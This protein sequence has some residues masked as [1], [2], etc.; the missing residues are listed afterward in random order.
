MMNLEKFDVK[1]RFNN[2]TSLGPTEL[3]DPLRNFFFRNVRGTIY[4]PL[5]SL[6]EP[7]F[8]P[9]DPIYKNIGSMGGFIAFILTKNIV[10][11]GRNL[12]G[13]KEIDNQ[14][15]SCLRRQLIPLQNPAANQLL[16]SLDLEIQSQ[17][18]FKIAYLAYRQWVTEHD[19]ED[20]DNK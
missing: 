6:A 15:I 16:N 14:V 12:D 7:S 17:M 4:M 8:N 9:R 20:V 18:A 5:S 1:H 19:K 2:A 11:L 3:V 13:G 10:H